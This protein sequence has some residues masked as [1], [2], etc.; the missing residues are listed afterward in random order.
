MQALW[1]PL[2]EQ[3]TSSG[4]HSYARFLGTMARSGWGETRRHLV[5]D[6]R[7]TATIVELI[8]S[9]MPTHAAQLRPTRWPVIVSMML[10][11]LLIIDLERLGKGQEALARFSDGVTMATA[12]LLAKL[13]E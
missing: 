3:T 7:Q 1:L 9:A 10:D 8:D 2:F 4:Q 6:F 13:G 12:A 5:G 11:T